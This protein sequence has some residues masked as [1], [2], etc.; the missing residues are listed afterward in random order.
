MGLP[1]NKNAVT[2]G[3]SD[4]ALYTT[5]TMMRSRCNNPE[6]VSFARYGGRGISVCRR[7]DSFPAFLEDMGERPDGTTLDRINSN[8]NYEPSNCRWATHLQQAQNKDQV[9]GERVNTAKLSASDV[10]EIRRLGDKH[11]QQ[12]LAARFGVHQA[13]ISNILLNRTW[14]HLKSVQNI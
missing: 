8:G 6:D 12:A 3:L 5:W 9:R 2:H 11:T 1:G 10:L 13:T 4:H 7:W 14:R